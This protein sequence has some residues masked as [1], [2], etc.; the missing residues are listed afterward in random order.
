M[1]IIPSQQF[2][3]D[4]KQLRKKFPSITADLR[5]LQTQLYE[6][7]TLGEPLGQNRYKI[8]LRITS[9][10]KGKS[11]GG[12]VITYVRLTDDELWLLTMYDKSDIANVS[13]AFLDDL[14]QHLE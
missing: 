13:D 12:R 6:N 2:A 7:P 4:L 1:R 11:G 10:G 9:K 14:V 8:R 5:E 3:K